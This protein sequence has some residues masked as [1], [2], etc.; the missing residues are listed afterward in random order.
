MVCHTAV[1][2][3]AVSCVTALCLANIVMILATVS[4]KPPLWY[5][6]PDS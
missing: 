1:C 3:G 2:V 5:M 4:L 6:H